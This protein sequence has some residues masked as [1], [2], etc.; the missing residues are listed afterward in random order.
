MNIYQTFEQVGI[1]P[2]VVLDDAKDAVPLAN[3]LLAGGVNV[4]EVT[5][6]TDAAEESIRLIAKEVPDMLV[7]AGTV[8]SIEQAERAVEA[9]AKFIVSPG[10]DLDVVNKAKELGVAMFPGTITPT[11]VT[12]AIKAGLGVV[13]FFPAGNFG[14]MKTLKSLAAPFTQMRFMPTGGVNANN[15][16]EFLEFDRVVAVG[17][18]WICDKKLI[19]EGKFEEI[20]RLTKEARNIYQQVRA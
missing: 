1:V 11:E 3:A 16:K 19:N 18:S 15:L 2:V 5:F 6:R 12:M 20:T 7:G 17:G 4:C 8:L 10:F 13:K 9:G 14:G